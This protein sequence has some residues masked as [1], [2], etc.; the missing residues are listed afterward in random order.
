MEF[1]SQGVPVVVSR[2]KIDLLYFDDSVVK[3][4]ESGN[5]EAMADAMLQIIKD[6][7][8]REALIAKGFEYVA[9][10]NWD[11]KKNDYLDLVDS[12]VTGAFSETD[13]GERVA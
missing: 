12:L 9:R 7:S 1:M 6:S 3:F 13:N 2:T 11:H 5:A 10:H 8:M 4:F